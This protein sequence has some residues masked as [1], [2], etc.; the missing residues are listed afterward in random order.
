MILNLR[1][2]HK[3]ADIQS[4]EIISKDIDELFAKLQEKYSIVEYIEISTCNRKEYFIHN[5]HIPEDEE[6]LSH[7]NKSIVIDYGQ[8]AVMHLLRM[9]SGLESMIVGEDQ[10]LGQ[11]KD[12]KHKAVKDRHCGK[13]LDA[14]FTKAIHV[15][16][17]VRNKTNINKGS[18][19]IGSAAIDLAEKYIGDLENK[20]VLV[21]GAGKMGKLV[22]KALAEKD[23]NAIFVANRTYYVAVDLAKDLGGEAILFNDLEKY[24]ATADLVISATS[25]PHPIIT[26]ERLLKSP[27]D[28]ESLMLIDI[29]NPRD[30]SE[31]VLELGVKS[32]NIDNLREIAEINTNLRKKEFAEAEN[33]IND[34]FILLKESFKIMKVDEL[35]G[36]LRASMEYIRERETQ[37]AI[38]KLSDVDGSDKILDN[39]T[40]SIVNKIFYDVSKKVKK[41]A[42]DENEDILAACE[43][44]F[45]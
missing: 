40:N 18:V 22:A 23:L 41:A 43:Y 6:L 28:Y 19:S 42:K 3:L 36:N 20:S 37:K 30:I 26:K 5:K 9:T 17:V 15:G 8:S 11:V 2:D 10:I 29:A 21:I 24:L 34:E 12:A 38:G 14:I 32:F 4:M 35:L 31:D 45:N 27:R 25:A 44:I 39:L 7:E 16:Q 33:I 13:I 1:V